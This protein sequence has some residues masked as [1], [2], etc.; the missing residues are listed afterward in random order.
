MRGFAALLRFEVRH[1]LGRIS[2]WVY[3]LV[4]AFAAY[5]LNIL[6][7]GAFPKSSAAI[8]GTSGNVLVNSPHVIL[9]L[10]SV[11]GLIGTLVVAAVSGNAGY[12]DFACEMHP[13]VF[14]SPT[15]K[16]RYVVCR[17]SAAVIT[18][19]V[20]MSGIALGLWVGTLMPF[21]D[22]GRIGPNWFAAYLRPYLLIVLPNVLFLSAIF[23][24]LALL[25]RKRMPHYIGGVGLLLGYLLSQILIGDLQTKWIAALT[26][27]FGMGSLQLET[28]YWTTIEKNTHLL[29]L[30]GWLL[31]NRLLWIGVALVIVALAA[32]RFRF[33]QTA[34]EG[35][36]TTRRRRRRALPEPESLAP[37]RVQV[38]VAHRSFGARAAWSQYVA[39][40]GRSFREVIFS[41][42]FAAIV[43]AGILVLVIN[44][45]NTDSI[46]GTKTWPMAWKMIEIL[47]GSFAL[48]VMILVTLYAGELVWRERD[49]KLDQVFDA[50]PTPTW[51][52][53][54]SK[55]SALMAM[56]VVLLMTVIAAGMITQAV[57]GFFRFEPK[58]YAEQLL[59]LQLLDYALLCVLA[60]T[61]HTLVNH[62][63]TGHF[64]L[65]LF[66]LFQDF[67]N[68]FGIEHPMFRY[69][70][71]LGH[72]YSDMNRFGWYLSPYLWFKL[73]W[74][75]SAVLMAVLS[76][77]IWPRG[78]DSRMA[79]RLHA[80][81]LRLRTAAASTAAVGVLL[82]LGAG[83]YIYYNTNVLNTYRSSTDSEQLQARYEKDY[84]KYEGL[85][86]PR[87]TAV[88]VAV[89]LYPGSGDVDARG[90]DTIVNKTGAPI[91]KIHVLIDENVDVRKLEFAAGAKLEHEDKDLGYR[92]FA[93]DH[94]LQPGEK[95]SL[96]FDLSYKKKGFS[97]DIQN[98]VVDNGTFVNSSILPSFGYD[99]SKELAL[100]R[101]RKKYGLKPKERMLDLD[102]PN[103]RLDNYI[104]RDA[105]WVDFDAVVSTRP[106]QIAL[107]PGYLQ[108]EWEENGRRYFHYVMDA[109]IL[110]FFSFLSARYKVAK[111]SWNDVA[112]EV[113][114]NPGHEFNV[115]RM[116]DGVKKALDYYSRE[117][118][119]YQYRQVRILEFPRYASFAQSFPN[120][121]PY[122]ESIGFIARVGKD[123]IDYPFYVTAHEVAHQWWA[124]QVIGAN[125]QGATVLSETLAQYSAL[126]VM[127]HEF[128]KDKMRRFLAYELDRYLMGRSFERKKEV[129]LLRVEDQPY[130]HYRKGS[131][132][133]YALQDA[134]G[135]EA[136]NQALRKLL[137][138]WAFKGPPYPTSRDLLADLRE[139]TPEDLQPWLSDL[140]EHITLYENR[141]KEAVARPVGEGHYAVTLK[142]ALKKVYAGE[143]GEETEAPLDD[144]IDIGV[145]DKDDK[146]LYLESRRLDGSVSEV[147]VTV[148]GKPH[149][150]GI[151]PYHKLIDRHP[152]DN[153]VTVS[154]PSS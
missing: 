21:I 34:S 77:L 128:G 89:D 61:V 76:N 41:P 10:T 68:L 106:D 124:H 49:L 98:M 131:V 91:D 133:M 94:P 87:I 110:N 13:L 18:G 132:I 26:D 32:T 109:P 51:I 17:Y 2:T 118:S 116:I 33:S 129:P 58:L 97:S 95:S 16:W 86:Q 57:Q 31:I 40:T 45:L 39:L 67:S 147:T 74:F 12:R 25:T 134:I 84:K 93:L 75:G 140:F 144:P 125:V 103:G 102:D 79:Q 101:V 115:Q 122:S 92:I 46:F 48:F 23:V 44:A 145:F 127:K 120:T 47:G 88:S 6:L 20:V 142:F 126:M 64:I 139:V 36:K 150:A 5:M 55:L 107:A 96:S 80:A 11:L 81:R 123:D 85:P 7:A 9:V 99:P 54:V 27:P 59:G 121:I 151:D 8:A 143:Q 73:Y 111:D 100:D 19:G 152:E 1:Y 154:E 138:D 56:V 130:I 65:I 37:A 71:D 70:S 60:L 35:R 63:Y 137:H 146:P 42:F 136:V 113:Y 153:E 148:D 50:S 43:L 119:P 108:R 4:M 135:E 105:D 24:S 52:G 149:K 53:F 90:T 82:S 83:G 28:Q 38:P 69:D 62:K 30:T 15:S 104:S 14:T 78:V 3:L 117:F 72:T 22:R 141:A 112:I 66:Y 29:G 114:Y